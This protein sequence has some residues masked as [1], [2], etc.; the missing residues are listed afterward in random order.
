MNKTK[1][2]S[3]KMSSTGKE[4]IRISKLNYFRLHPEKRLHFYDW[5]GKRHKRSTIE[6]M[7][8]NN[9]HIKPSEEHKKKLSIIH[10]GKKASHET[11][12]KLRK[13]LIG[14]TNSKGKR[15][16]D[17]SRNKISGKNNHNWKGGLSFVEYPKEFD[18][19]L[20]NLIKN[21]DLFFC[22]LCHTEE[23]NKLSIHHIDHNK[24]NCQ[25][26]N[27]IVLCRS[28]NSKVNYNSE[29][30][31]KYF[32]DLISFKKILIEIFDIRAK[33]SL[34]YGQSWRIWGINGIANQI[35]SKIVR[36]WNLESNN[37][38]PINE[39]LKDSYKDLAV[40]SLMGADLLSRDKNPDKKEL[41]KLIIKR[42]GKI[43]R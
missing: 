23:L 31:E 16:S 38:E 17:I 21:R 11:T 27:L 41:K 32:N 39:S 10:K 29:Y 5:T 24:K 25:I 7:I 40:Y 14:N 9:R 6:K 35:R 36:I 12:E 28:C 22:Q 20:K 15:W 34:D 19:K 37:K 8:K 13:S 3:W 26:D 1:R 2:K 42:F 4:N 43:K 30:W 18:K 33:K